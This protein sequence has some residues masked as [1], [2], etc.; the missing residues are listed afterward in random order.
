MGRGKCGLL[1]FTGSSEGGK[2]GTA[3]WL[4][5]P[6]SQLTP[7]KGLWV[8]E[9]SVISGTDAIA[10]HCSDSVSMHFVG[11]VFLNLL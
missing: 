8:E 9:Q 3:V 7:R 10:S 11:E 4:P 1:G 6:L 5:S 2:V